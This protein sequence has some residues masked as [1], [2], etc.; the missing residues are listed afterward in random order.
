MHDEIKDLLGAYALD[1]V[2]PDEAALVAAHLGGC[3][4]CRR[5][6]DGYRRVAALLPRQELAPPDALWE[7]IRRRTT[8][9]RGPIRWPQWVGV[10]AGVALVAAL[11][12]QSLRMSDLQAEVVAARSEAARLQAELESLDL[13]DLAQRLAQREG[14]V[15]VEL[16]T[17][18]GPAG[19]VVLLP[20]GTG[21]I[22]SHQLPPL[23]PARTYQLWAVQDG[24]VISAGILGSQPGVVAFHVDSSRLEALVITEEE[25]GGVAV[26]SQPAVAV[27]QRDA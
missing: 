15:T 22:T 23:D 13:D 16:Q 25:A 1:A 6:V 12:V 3:E 7:R 8:A 18:A 4:E 19:T 21:V 17:G 2:E 26:S 14:A 11:G 10:A 9:G 24:E 20:D 27:W 5:E